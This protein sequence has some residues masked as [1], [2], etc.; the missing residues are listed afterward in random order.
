MNHQQIGL[1]LKHILS[2]SGE[3][4]DYSILRV[5]VEMQVCLELTV[6]SES[7][8]DEKAKKQ[9]V[10]RMMFNDFLLQN[11]DVEGGDEL[12]VNNYVQQDDWDI[13]Q[14]RTTKP[15]RSTTIRQIGIPRVDE[16]NKIIGLIK[17]ISLNDYLETLLPLVLARP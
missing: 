12:G 15:V 17:L 16:N 9:I 8:I 6:E 14:E 5:L 11:N 2:A 7:I 4:P 3:K 10:S 1:A 13:N